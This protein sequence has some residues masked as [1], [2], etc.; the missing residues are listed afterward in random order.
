MYTVTPQTVEPVRL[1]FVLKKGLISGPFPT[2]YSDGPLYGTPNS[3]SDYFNHWQTEHLRNAQMH[4]YCYLSNSWVHTVIDQ[5]ANAC[6]MDQYSVETPIPELQHAIE[7]FLYNI[8]PNYSFDRLLRGVYEDLLINGNWYGRIKFDRGQPVAIHRIHFK[9]IVPNITEDD[10]EIKSYAVYA[11]GIEG[12]PTKII[13]AREILHFTLSDVN[14]MG[15]G[16]SK[17]EALDS[18]LALDRHATVYQQGFFENGVKAGDIFSADAGMTA[19]TYTRDKLYLEAFSEPTLAHLPIFLSGDWKVIKTG[20]EHRKDMEF[21]A[22]RNWNREEILSVYNV[23]MS[24]VASDKIGTLGSTGKQ[25]DWEHFMNSVVAPLQ[26]QVF[27]DFNRQFMVRTLNMHKAR[28]LPPGRPRVRLDDL[29]AAAEMIKVGFTGNEIRSIL[30]LDLIEGLDEPLY[31]NPSATIIGIPG[32]ANSVFY[33]RMGP[34]SG[35]PF[36][37]ADEIKDSPSTTD[38]TAKDEQDQTPYEDLKGRLANSP[39]YMRTK[40]TAGTQPTANTR[41]QSNGS[42][43]QNMVYNS[44][45]GVTPSPDFPNNQARNNK[46]TGDGTIP[47]PK[48][49]MTPPQKRRRPKPTR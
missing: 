2:G 38:P 49:N 27:E 4:E 19:E 14:D 6:T 24:L 18:T 10:P 42:Y 36:A 9:K 29:K 20:Q 1:P 7:L 12:K 13:P 16:L 47:R 15:V 21:L 23:P 26:K 28:L 46:K 25:E 45:A 5:I 3:T 31:F 22:L 44:A 37:L 8:S 32:D 35:A 17:L 48:T 11:R 40:Q 41:S 34:I 30:N 33:T 43:K 39:G